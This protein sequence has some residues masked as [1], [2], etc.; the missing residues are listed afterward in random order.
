[1]LSLRRV[2]RRCD[3]APTP[4]LPLLPFE[5]AAFEGNVSDQRV[6]YAVAGILGVRGM[7]GV[8]LGAWSCSHR[9]P[10]AQTASSAALSVRSELPN[11]FAIIGDAEIDDRHTYFAFTRPAV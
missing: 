8:C 6:R 5:L 9:L 3:R 1:M 10:P 11:A 2:A 7:L 4:T